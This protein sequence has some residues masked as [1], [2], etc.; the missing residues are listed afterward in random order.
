[1]LLFSEGHGNFSFEMGLYRSSEY[2]TS[3]DVSEYPVNVDP[4]GH[5]YCE[6]KLDTSDTGLVLLADTCVATPS[7]N[8][9]DS[10]QYIFIDD[11]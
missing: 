5:L 4:F 9:A 8:P 10:M 7:M 1:M 3:Y 11:G 2:K 6:A